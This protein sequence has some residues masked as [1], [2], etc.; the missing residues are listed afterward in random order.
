VGTAHAQVGSIADDYKSA[1]VSGSRI[2]ALDFGNDLFT[3]DDDGGSFQLRQDTSLLLNITNETFE[4]V[5]AFGSTVIAV[6]EDGLILRSTDS[7]NSWL[8]A[9]T[10][11]SIQG[12]LSAA[13]ARS[14][15]VNPNIWLAVGNDNEGG[16]FHL[17]NDDGENWTIVSTK[18]GTIIEDV[19]WT[20]SRWLYCGSDDSFF[21]V[22]FSST[23][24]IIW[25]RSNLPPGDSLLAL[26]T[27]GNG[28]VMAVGF[29]GRVIRSTDDGLNF[30]ELPPQT[31]D[32][33]S[34]VVDSAGDFY[35]GGDQRL[36]VKISGTTQTTV[37]PATTSASPILDFVLIDGTPVAVGSFSVSVRTIPLTLEIS[38]GGTK[39]YVLTV[40]Q[41]LTGKS[42]WVETTTDLT[43]DDWAII[44]GTPVPGTG[45]VLTFDVDE[46]GD[47]RFWRVVEF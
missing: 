18:A 33:Y 8:Q 5:E 26:A 16:T 2:V 44:S 17:S 39:D 38:A 15:G 11:P 12:S 20:G 6:G 47:R 4:S 23:D 9:A 35:V 19:I 29:S 24:G 3:S 42:Y 41:S 14:D 45:S 1:T 43:A 10:T 25:T 30:S 32:L 46:N 40:S 21:G 28:V 34:L 27:D 31:V 7:G 37:V 13:A 36:I 22:V